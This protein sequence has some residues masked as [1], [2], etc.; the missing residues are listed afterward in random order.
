MPKVDVDGVVRDV[1]GN[2]YFSINPPY[3]KRT[4]R[5]LRKKCIKSQ[6]QD[7]YIVYCSSCN[8]SCKNP[9]A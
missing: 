3:S 2:E 7:K 8:L 9:L 1:L 6:F 5:R 4:P